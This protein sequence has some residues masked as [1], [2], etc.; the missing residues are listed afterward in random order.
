[1]VSNLQSNR[2][3]VHDKEIPKEDASATVDIHESIVL[4][5]TKAKVGA[6]FKRFKEENTGC[7]SGNGDN[8]SSLRAFLKVK[9]NST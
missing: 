7:N 3:S 5:A 1:M 9:G 4:C 2:S 8:M 6:F